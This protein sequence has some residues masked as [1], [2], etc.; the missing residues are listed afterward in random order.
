MEQNINNFATELSNI[1]GQPIGVDHIHAMSKGRFYYTQ[2]PEAGAPMLLNHYRGPFF[3]DIHPDD[4]E[5]IAS[6]EVSAHEY[7]Y[8][9]SWQVGY[10]WGGGNMVGGGYYQPF[11][12]SGRKEE[13]RRYLKILSCR[14]RCNASGYKPTEELCTACHVESCPFSKYKEG[15]WENEME[16]YDPRVDLFKALCR[17]FEN[18]FPGYTFRGFLCSNVEDSIIILSPNGHYAE[19]EP[20]SFVV[21]ASENVIRDLM[22]RKVTPDDWDEYVKDFKFQ[23]KMMLSQACLDATEEN[24]KASFADVDYVAKKKQAETEPEPDIS[25]LLAKKGDEGIIAKI[26]GFFKNIF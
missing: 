14:G 26:C 18:Q 1:I 16:E 2:A 7:I 20:F 15:L 10:Y 9:A 25:E 11:D 6:G 22:M 5:K 8:S 3:V 24:V 21:Y 13:I 19:E 4:L 12:I 23:I 17:R